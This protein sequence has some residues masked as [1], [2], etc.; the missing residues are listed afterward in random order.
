M[1]FTLEEEQNFYLERKILT[2]ENNTLLT[3]NEKN[4]KIQS[5]KFDVSCMTRKQ[6][7]KKMHK[8]ERLQKRK[9]VEECIE[10]VKEL[11]NASNQDELVQRFYERENSFD[12][13]LFKIHPTNRTT[14]APF[15]KLWKK[16]YVTN[17]QEDKIPRLLIPISILDNC[18]N[19]FLEQIHLDIDTSDDEVR[20]KIRFEVLTLLDKKG[21][22]ALK[23]IS[24][25]A[26]WGILFSAMKKNELNEHKSISIHEDKKIRDMYYNC[27]NPLS[28][29]DYVTYSKNTK[30]M[31]YEDEIK[32]IEELEELVFGLLEQDIAQLYQVEEGLKNKY[33][34]VLSN[35]FNPKRN[36]NRRIPASTNNSWKGIV[37]TTT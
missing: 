24:F 27:R 36:A 14:Y 13:K 28:H 8:L 21:V 10:P 31:S 6:L 15:L 18:I 37:S 1:E 34:E 20:N 22:D 32:Q 16:A 9:I 33:I 30:G 19:N 29:G 7:H 4:L 26:K 17:T 11:R 5:L 25:R 12:N 3:S 23:N 2:I 35:A